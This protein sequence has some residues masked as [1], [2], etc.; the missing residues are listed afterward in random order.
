MYHQDLN[1]IKSDLQKIVALTESYLKQISALKW[2]AAWNIRRYQI[3]LAI[4]DAEMTRQLEMLLGPDGGLSHSSLEKMPITG[5]F[6]EQDLEALGLSGVDYSVFLQH[7]SAV[8]DHKTKQPL[9][10]SDAKQVLAAM[11]NGASDHEL[12]KLRKKGTRYYD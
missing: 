5:H 11:Q 7:K 10:S 9:T 12:R 8:V 3:K 1:T 6:T 2:A 4:S